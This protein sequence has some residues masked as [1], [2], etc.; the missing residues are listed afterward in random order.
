MINQDPLH[1]Q[2]QQIFAFDT[3]IVPRMDNITTYFSVLLGFNEA[4]QHLQVGLDM[5]K[6]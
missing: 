2:V 5:D 4:F 1:M 6:K 3:K